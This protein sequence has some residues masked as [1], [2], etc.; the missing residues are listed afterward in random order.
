MGPV[1]CAS[2][3]EGLVFEQACPRVR[4]NALIDSMS[5]T[6]CS[7][8]GHE[9]DQSFRERRACLEQ[10]HAILGTLDLSIHFVQVDTGC[11]LRLGYTARRNPP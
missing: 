9:A 3:R 2:S 11:I 1:R 5:Y 8:A 4:H 7:G 6:A 10:Q